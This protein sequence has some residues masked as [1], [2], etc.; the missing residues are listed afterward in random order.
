M[1]CL[2]GSGSLVSFEPGGFFFQAEDGIRDHCVTGVQTCALPISRVQV[3]MGRVIRC[4]R[5]GV[6]VAGGRAAQP[7]ARSQRA[8]H[9]VWVWAGLL[10][11]VGTLAA[12]G[13]NALPKPADDSTGPTGPPAEHVATPRA[14]PLIAT[15]PPL[16]NP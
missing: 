16:P 5:C 1:Y 6:V 2:R 15:A 14:K 13:V 4:P 12:L 9:P 10:A 8:S 3:E 11:V 7:A